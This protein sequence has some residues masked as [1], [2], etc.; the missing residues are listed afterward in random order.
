MTQHWL[1]G[2]YCG[3]A[4]V[5]EGHSLCQLCQLKLQRAFALQRRVDLL[6]ELLLRTPEAVHLLHA[7]LQLAL[8]QRA[9]AQ[10]LFSLYSQ[11]LHLEVG[12]KM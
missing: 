3:E 7:A 12:G 10:L 11:A 5:Q 6:F 9:L 1:S 8:S 4:A 2:Y